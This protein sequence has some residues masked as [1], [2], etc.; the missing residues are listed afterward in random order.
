MLEGLPDLG[1]WFVDILYKE[2]E[3]W[4]VLFFGSLLE[5]SLGR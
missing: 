2:A 5:E 4:N 3:W 1:K